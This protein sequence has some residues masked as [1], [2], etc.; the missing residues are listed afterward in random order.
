MGSKSERLGRGCM[1]QR[2]PSEERSAQSGQLCTDGVA[3]RVLRSRTF[4][5]L[6]QGG[7]PKRRREFKLCLLFDSDEFEAHY[8]PTD[9]DEIQRHRTSFVHSNFSGWPAAR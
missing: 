2:A 6:S 7:I 5:P 9:Y 1:V 4:V 8:K 3:R